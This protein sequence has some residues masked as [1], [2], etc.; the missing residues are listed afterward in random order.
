VGEQKDYIV[1]IANTPIDSTEKSK[2]LSAI[3]DIFVTSH[4]AEVSD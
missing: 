1:H 4:A 3:S 2:G